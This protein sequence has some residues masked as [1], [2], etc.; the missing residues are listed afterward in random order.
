MAPKPET[1]RK[2]MAARVKTALARGY[3]LAEAHFD[4]ESGAGVLT[5]RNQNGRMVALFFDPAVTRF[6]DEVEITAHERLSLGR[7]LKKRIADDIAR[8]TA[9]H[10]I[11]VGA[12]F[13]IHSGATVKRASFYRV[14]SIPTPR[15]IGCVE[16][17]EKAIAGTIEV[18]SVVPDFDREP[19]SREPT[20]T[21]TITMETGEARL[22]RKGWRASLAFGS[23]W[24]GKPL[25][26][27]QD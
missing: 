14:V 26:T 8:K 27:Y 17:P 21:F 5:A 22:E 9:P 10:D 4:A 11:Q 12:V 13:A 3:H 16:I 2:R 6:Y 20:T 7:M 25:Q 24:N 1:I 19:V 15:T 23:V 18:G